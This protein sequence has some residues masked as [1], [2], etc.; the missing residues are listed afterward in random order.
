MNKN[1]L[2]IASQFSEKEK[3]TRQRKRI[4][5]LL[6]IAVVFFTLN[7]LMLPAITIEKQTIC[8]NVEHIHS[9]KCYSDV[10]TP[11]FLALSEY[12]QHGKECYVDGVLLCNNLSTCLHRH[13][14]YCYDSTGVLVCP[15]EEITGHIHSEE[16][17]E[18]QKNLICELAEDYHMHDDSCFVTENGELICSVEETEGH[19]HTDECY[20]II[21][22]DLICQTEETEGHIHS[23]ECYRI[24]TENIC[25]LVETEGHKHTEQCKSIENILNCEIAEDENHTHTEECYTANEILICTLEETEPHTHTEQCTRQF[26]ELVCEKEEIPAHTHSAECYQDNKELIC[27]NEEIQPHTHNTECYRQIKTVI[28]EKEEKPDGHFHTER[29]YEE[30][31]N[32][33]CTEKEI[34]LHSHTAECYSENGELTCGLEEVKEHIHSENCTKFVQQEEKTLVCTIEEHTHTD[35]CYPPETDDGRQ[36]VC[37]REEHVHTDA[38]GDICEI[39]EH[40]H[41]DDCYKPAETP[42]PTPTATPEVDIYDIS[43]GPAVFV[44]YGGIKTEYTDSQ[45]ETASEEADTGEIMLFALKSTARSVNDFKNYVETNGGNVSVTVVDQDNKP[46]PTD[47]NGNLIVTAGTSYKLTLGAYSPKGIEPGYY[48]YQ[49]PAGLDIQ[50]GTGDCI[51]KDIDGSEVNIGTWTV[52]EDG[53]I[54]FDFNDNADKYTDLRIS[55]TMGVS[56]KEN[57]NNIEFD[58]DIT[59]V[60]TPP[61]EQEQTTELGKWGRQGDESKGQDP[62]KIYWTVTIKGYADSDIPGSTL[63]DKIITANHTYTA[64]DMRNGIKIGISERDPITDKEIRWHSWTVYPGDPNLIWTANGWQYIMPEVTDECEWCDG[65][66]LGNEG[67]NYYI[68]YTSTPNKTNINGTV[69][70]QNNITIDNQEKDG[71]ASVK[72]GSDIAGIIKD[73][74]FQ[75]DANGGKYIWDVYATIPGMKDGEKA[76]YFWYIQDRIRIKDDNQN[77]VDYLNNA[78]NMATVT[79][80]YP[81]GTEILVNNITEATADDPFCWHNGWEDDRSGEFYLRQIDFY[82]KCNCTEDTCQ[83]WSDD[84]CWSKYWANKNFCQCWTEK[85]DITFKFTYETTQ[86]DKDNLFVDFG[87][88]GNNIQNEALL[89]YKQPDDENSGEWKDITV[90]DVRVRVPIPGVFKKELTEAYNGY[91]ANYTISVNEAKMQLTADGSP[92]T[93][94]DEMTDT[95]AYINGSLVINTEDIDGNTTTLTYGVDYTTEYDGSGTKKDSAGNPV[96]VLKIDILNPKP[97]QYILNY[98]ATL[99][100]PTGSS[101]GVKYSNS[102]SITLWG[103]EITSDTEDIMHTD[104]NVSAKTYKVS[105][106]KLSAADSR[107]LAGAVF[108]LYNQNG[109]LIASRTTDANGD[110]LF[111]TNVTEGVILRD[112]E[113][114]YIQEIKAPDGY[115]RDDTKHWICFCVYADANEC[116]F[117]PPIDVEYKRIPENDIFYGNIYN[118]T[119]GYELPRT[120]GGGTQYYTAGGL[121]LIGGAAALLLY[122]SKKCRKEDYTSP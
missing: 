6:S 50:G 51:I 68:E 82:C 65:L 117:T 22:T 16:C 99:V 96:H 2:H 102:A 64:S 15:L 98:D 84:G 26:K 21:S 9:D 92:L 116:T 14:E 75:G 44:F 40:K 48:Q 27:G 113:L 17:Y 58:G 87:G 83:A 18:L 54:S 34:I 94:Y 106:K 77:T 69:S 81:D 90:N 89:A 80:I 59:V 12:H 42:A 115:I 88:Q 4:F 11:E 1:L 49:L 60:V 112:H 70:Y 57:S 107:P 104:I 25:R 120:G 122:R 23:E 86:D 109:G 121:V 111:E 35:E 20:H 46:L 93:I 19:L 105:I 118:S 91:T 38:C 63:T 39:Q 108:G 7:A 43:N 74:V 119:Y 8:G 10:T 73:G 71:W 31:K 29:C 24:S 53:L 45:I 47:E 114:Y 72:H 76:V 66:V 36:L 30:T 55:A 28:C 5:S 101:A 78:M 61:E 110:I 41:T 3:K 95:L 52:T 103:K 85:N 56:F 100:I 79:A 37:I 62:D 13:N 97:V 67:W 32:L 33:I